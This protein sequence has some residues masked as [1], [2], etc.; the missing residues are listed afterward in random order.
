LI[1]WLTAN[2]PAIKIHKSIG[3]KR[4]RM[5]DKGLKSVYQVFQGIS[6]IHQ[7][8]DRRRKQR[9]FCANAVSSRN[10]TLT[11]LVAICFGSL[12]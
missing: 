4:G 10:V 12:S 9:S 6:L 2:F 1:E 11:A 7:L 5:A 3:S 8:P